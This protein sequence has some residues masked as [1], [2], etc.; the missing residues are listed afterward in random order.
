MK[1]T[2]NV[3]LDN[4]KFLLINLEVTYNYKTASWL[5]EWS[6]AAEKTYKYTETTD[7]YEK[8]VSTQ[9]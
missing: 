3:E 1:S 5:K 4:E 2:E 6:T 7:E 9:S 8:C